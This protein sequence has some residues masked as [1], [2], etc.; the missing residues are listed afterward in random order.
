MARLPIAYNNGYHSTTN[1]AIPQEA[2]DEL[3]DY[4]RLFDMSEERDHQKLQPHVVSERVMNSFVST[5]GHRADGIVRYLHDRDIRQQQQQQDSSTTDGGVDTVQLTIETLQYISYS[6]DRRLKTGAWPKLK[7]VV[8]HLKLYLYHPCLDDIERYL[9]KSFRLYK[10][11]IGPKDKFYTMS[12]EK[13]AEYVDLLRSIFEHAFPDYFPEFK[14]Y[15]SLVIGLGFSTSHLKINIEMSDVDLSRL[16]NRENDAALNDQDEPHSFVT[17]KPYLESLQATKVRYDIGTGSVQFKLNGVRIEYNFNKEIYTR[18]YDMI[19]EYFKLDD[20]VLPFMRTLKRF[21]RVNLRDM[22][23][24][25][26]AFQ[27]MALSYLVSLD[28]PVLPNLQNLF[29]YDPA[30]LCQSEDCNSKKCFW[31]TAIYRNRR[32]GVAG[33]YHDCVI[34]DRTQRKTEHEVDFNSTTQ[35]HYW[36]SANTSPLDELV[37]D[38]FC[39]WGYQFDY[40]ARAIAVQKGGST[41]IKQEFANDSLVIE[42][43][44]MSGVNL[45][46]D[47]TSI[48]LF[49]MTLQCAFTKMHGSLETEDIMQ[50]LSPMTR[51][52]KVPED[53][54]SLPHQK[55]ETKEI[56][57]LL[58]LDLPEIAEDEREIKCHCKKLCESFSSLGTPIQLIDYDYN[59]K[60]ITFY[61]ENPVTVDVPSRYVMDNEEVH[62]V[63][64]LE[65]VKDPERLFEPVEVN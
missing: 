48:G 7:S 61:N 63:E 21:F 57:T 42:D 12:V 36:N 28:P 62:I 16:Y 46:A 1:S 59:V 8:N 43:P 22:G 23:L 20:R 29:V 64:L 37:L 56:K 4:M 40:S 53:Y 14:P 10:R 34:L 15:G 31:D 49:V 19:A 47:L 17:M 33:C 27:V 9:T 45:G 30:D 39:Y 50:R 54:V 13:Q 6:K 44:F 65:S 5:S 38:F 51:K 52:P 32:V 3:F 41:K 58:F 35:Q 18:P 2:I 25:F 24:R 55:Q 11:P 60:L 26:Y